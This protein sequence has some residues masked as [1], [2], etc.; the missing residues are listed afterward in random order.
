MAASN[1]RVT[2]QSID[3]NKVPKSVAFDFITSTGLLADTIA[4]ADALAAAYDP[5]I[6]GQITRMEATYLLAV[7]GGVKSAPVSGSNNTVGAL[8]GYDTTTPLEQATY[9]I[10]SWIPAGFQA[11][12][13]NLVDVAETD[14]AAFLA[15]MLA[16]TNNTKLA[17]E[18]SIALSAL[19][20]AIKSDRK[21]RRALGRVR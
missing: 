9:W 3:A 14:V 15:F 10:P 19:V 5:V 11:A 17:N 8:L 13:Q 2:I 12:H 1:G 7:P 21:Q 18:D 6:Q 20:K 4:F 16:T